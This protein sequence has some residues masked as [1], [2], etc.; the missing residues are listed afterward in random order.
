MYHQRPRIR[1]NYRGPGALHCHADKRG[2]QRST[3]CLTAL[4]CSAAILT[5]PD[6]PMTSG[7]SV[8]VR[9]RL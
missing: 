1:L 6:V 2:E 8:T 9:D 7:Y 3:Y 5:D 4:V